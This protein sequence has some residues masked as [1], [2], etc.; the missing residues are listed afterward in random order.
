MDTHTGPTRRSRGLVPDR[1]YD[2]EVTPASKYTQGSPG[3]GV[4]EWHAFSNDTQ[5]PPNRGVDELHVVVHEAIHKQLVRGRVVAYALGAIEVEGVSRT[6][7]TNTT[8]ITT[9]YPSRQLRAETRR[10]DS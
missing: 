7:T 3:R 10:C 8:T 1:I 6:T 5:G 4:D 2:P 9:T